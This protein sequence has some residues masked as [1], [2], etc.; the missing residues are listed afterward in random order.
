MA[1]TPIMIGMP[2]SSPHKPHSQ[3]HAS[4]LTK[5]A[6]GL[7]LL[8]RLVSHGGKSG[9]TNT[10]MGRLQALRGQLTPEIRQLLT[11]E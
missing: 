8:V 2:S 6:T 10:L 1:L 5:M 7:M 3:P 4:T 11:G 9:I